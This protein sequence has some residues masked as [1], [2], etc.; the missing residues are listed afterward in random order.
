MSICAKSLQNLPRRGGN[1]APVD[2][3]FGWGNQT[4]L[5]WWPMVV[6]VTLVNTIDMWVY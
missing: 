2:R 4:V 3:N 1:Q 5:T 6:I